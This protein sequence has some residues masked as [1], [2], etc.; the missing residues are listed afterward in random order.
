MAVYVDVAIWERHD[1]RWCHLLADDPDELHAFAARLGIERRRFQSRPNR[2]WIDHYDIDEPR[3][4]AAI[5]GGA[6]ELTRREIVEQLARKRALALAAR[7][8]GRE[9]GQPASTTTASPT[10]TAPPSSTAP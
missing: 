4:R 2:P 5:A 10:D 7:E 8:R 1:R 3:R 6:I 9:R